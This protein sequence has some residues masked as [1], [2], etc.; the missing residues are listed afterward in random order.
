VQSDVLRVNEIFGPTFQGEG[1]NLG[2]PCVFVRLAGCNLSCAWCDTPYSW[3]WTRYDKAA[4]VHRQTVV[5]VADRV[6]ELAGDRVRHMVVSGGEPLLQG[7]SVSMLV[8]ALR[9]DNW[10]SELETA[11]TVMPPSKTLVDHFTVSPKLV[12]SHQAA[13]TADRRL[14]ADVLCYLNTTPSHCFKFV[15]QHPDDY[16]EIDA[17]VDAHHLSPVYIMP[18][19]VDGST[20]NTTLIAVADGAVQRNYTLTTRLQIL[21]YGQRRAV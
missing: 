4:E 16:D 1:V 20:L 14:N 12:N 17:L 8:D 9:Q 15:V 7:L 5:D 10:T 21:A 3:D 13:H 6:R 11:G 2:K 19:G 18:E